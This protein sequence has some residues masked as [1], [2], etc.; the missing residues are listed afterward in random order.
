MWQIG[1]GTG[2]GKSADFAVYDPV[3]LNLGGTTDARGHIAR[4]EANEA[5]VVTAGD[6]NLNVPWRFLSL[7]RQGRRKRVT[8]ALD[9][10]K[11]RF[12][13]DDEVKFRDGS[14]T[15]Q[16]VIARFGSKRA[17]V[18]IEGGKSWRVPYG[19]LIHAGRNGFRRDAERCSGHE[20][21]RTSN[22]AAWSQALEL[23]V[24]RRN[25]AR[26][27]LYPWRKGDHPVAAVLPQS[28]EADVRDTILHEIAHALAG[29]KHNHDKVWREKARA[30]GCTAERCHNVV[31]A[32]PRY[33]MFCEMCG[34]YKKANVR[35]RNTVCKR[36]RAT[37]EVPEL[38]EAGV[39][40]HGVRTTVIQS[41]R[42]VMP[43]PSFGLHSGCR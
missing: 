18:V 9:Q 24:R 1:T 39:E 42:G 33:I 30:I 4:K 43:R 19:D 16:G 11:A 10:E 25:K 36:C 31:F 38:H 17:V 35:R 28:A 21:G 8:A 13:P 3:A 23:S 22:L 29:P 32:P 14:N 26:R 34:W 20:A 27:I 7:D 2:M 12:R 5:V 40:T 6:D 15:V 41:P 37:P